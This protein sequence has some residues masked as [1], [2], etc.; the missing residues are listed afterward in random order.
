MHCLF[1]FR[2]LLEKHTCYCYIHFFFFYCYKSS[3]VNLFSICIYFLTCLC[4][5]IFLGRLTLILSVGERIKVS[6]PKKM[7]EHRVTPKFL[8]SA[9][10]VINQLFLEHLSSS[11]TQAKIYLKLINLYPAGTKSD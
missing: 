9:N 8:T 5:R 6:L 7:C 10:I 4:K 1:I 3:S 11:L 2:L